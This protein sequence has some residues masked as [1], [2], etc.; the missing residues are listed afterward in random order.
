M[1]HEFKS[2]FYNLLTVGSW[3]NYSN[4]ICL[5]FPMYKM[6][7]QKKHLPHKVTEI[8]KWDNK[9]KGYKC[10]LSLLLICN[11]KESSTIMFF[12]PYEF[13]LTTWW[14]G[15]KKKIRIMKHWWILWLCKLN[16]AWCNW[17]YIFIKYL[18]AI[19]NTGDDWLWAP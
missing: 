4:S 15:L 6:W 11:S 14:L 17:I 12:C 9:S 7:L 2:L 10:L 13:P 3:A 18:V 5:N 8:I 1:L 19:Y 16:N